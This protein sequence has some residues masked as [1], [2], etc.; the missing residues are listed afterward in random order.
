[1]P[2]IISRFLWRAPLLPVADLLRSPRELFG[3]ELPALAL[4][5]AQPTLARAARLARPGGEAE[6]ALGN[7]ARRAAFRPTP[8]GLWAG[9][10]VGQLGERTRARSGPMR[11]HITV[12]YARLAG[13]ARA[14]LDE[15]AWRARLRLRVT[16]SLVRDDTRALWLAAGQGAAGVAREAELDE[17]LT[18]LIDAAADWT[19]FAELAALADEELLLVLC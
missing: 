16:P 8:H 3:A 15:P 19:P 2:A 5:L 13:L 4:E 7:F 10:G 17:T 18:R 11:A 1:L 12:V 14:R 6:R 9:A